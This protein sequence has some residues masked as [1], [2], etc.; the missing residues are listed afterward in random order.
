MRKKIINASGRSR[1]I[2][3]YRMIEA[4]SY[5]LNADQEWTEKHLIEPLRAKDTEALALWRVVSRQT[6]CTDILRIIGNDMADRTA[7]HRL[8][9]TT[10]SSLAS[11]L[12]VETLHALQQKRDPAVGRNRVQQMIRSLD[13]EVRAN[14]G[15]VITRFLREQSEQSDQRPNPPLSEE[16][17][18]SA[19]KPFLQKFW[20]QEHSLV[21]PAVSSGLAA[22]PVAARGDFAEAVAT[23]QRFLVPFDC[24]SMLEYGLYRDDK[25]KPNLSMIDDEAKAQGLLNLLD[26]TVGT[27]ENAA[28]P[29]DLGDALEQVRKVAPSLAKTPKFRRLET[30]A[31]R[32]K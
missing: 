28:I 29:L 9:R 11:S 4:L 32:V 10:R 20:P 6:Q 14:C 12:L 7:D 27:T 26:L 1:L 31:R 24:W 16:L 8:D 18:Q 22:L 21:S 19:A 2:V 13:D 25:E 30:A 17:F 5:S 23:I 3:K 15:E